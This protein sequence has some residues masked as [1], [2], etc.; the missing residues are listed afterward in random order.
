MQE[1]TDSL[2]KGREEEKRIGGEEERRGGGEECPHLR[3]GRKMAPMI[4][5]HTMAFLCCRIFSLED[6]LK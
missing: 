1:R 2:S 6:G 5:M 4:P 3:D